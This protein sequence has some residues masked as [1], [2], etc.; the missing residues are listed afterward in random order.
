M[1]VMRCNPAGDDVEATV[2]ERQVLRATDHIRPHARRRVAGYDL[3]ACLPQAP[4]HMPAAGRNVE[5]RARATRPRDQEVE[6]ASLPMCVARA[7]EAFDSA[8]AIA[9]FA[10]STARSAASSIVGSV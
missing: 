8:P 4:R 9:H 7:V 3:E 5:S 6:V 1:E 10:S 2:G